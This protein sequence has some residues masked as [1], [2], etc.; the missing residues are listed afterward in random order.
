M[1]EVRS[2]QV[3]SGVEVGDEE[4]GQIMRRSGEGAG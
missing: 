3:G 4:V 2:R 1:I